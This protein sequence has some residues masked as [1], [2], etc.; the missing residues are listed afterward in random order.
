ME[1]KKNSIIYKLVP[2]TQ[3]QQLSNDFLSFFHYREIGPT[4]QEGGG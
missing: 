2:N 3:G 1:S 4:R